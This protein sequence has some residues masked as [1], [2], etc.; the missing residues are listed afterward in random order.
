MA[1]MC[2]DSGN[3]MAIAQQ[4]IKQ[5]QQQEQLQQQ[6]Q[7]Q[8]QQQQQF[9]GVNPLCLSPWTSTTH[10]TLTNS[11][12][13]GYGLTG[14][15][16]A[17]PFQVAGGTDGGEPGFQFPNLEHHST[18]FRFADFGGGPGGEFDSDEWMESLIGGGDSTGSSNLQSG[19][20]A[21]QTSSEFTTLYGDPFSSCP[22]RLSIG[23]SPPPP[24]SS[25]L[26][27]VI[28]SET[29]KNLNSL[30]PQTSPWVAPSSSPPPIVQ[31]VCKESKVVSVDVLPC[32]SPESFSSKPLLKSLVECARLAE[33]EPENVVKSLIRL[34]ES[35]SQQGDPMERVGFYFL[36]ALYNGL[37]SCQAERTPSIF[38][39]TPEELTLSYKAFNDACPYSKF[40][41]LTANQAI[42]EATEKATRIHIVDF[43][44]VHG[45]QWAAFLQALATR[46][47][48]KPVSVRISGIPSVVLGNS[49]AA[50][51]LA[52]GNRLRD[53]AK[54]LDLNFE[55]EPILTPVQE[56]NGS[57]FRIDPDEILAVNFM[58]QLYN[59]LD[60][61]NVGV[62]TALSLAKSLNPSI[63]TLGEYEVN[64]NDVGFLQR[65]KNA[66]KYYS[67][68]F[69]SLD[70]SLTRDSPERV[71]VERLIL[72]RRIAGAVGLD[73]GGTRRECMEDKEHWRELMEGAGFKSVTLSHYA[74][75]Q[76]KILLWNYNY[77]SSFGLIDSAPGFLSL[78]WKDNPLLTVSSW[79]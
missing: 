7:Q 54:L 20:E 24:P 56:L 40:A 64:L 35:V 39:T 14:A 53:F 33:S 43:G 34:R 67:T 44:I 28:F 13:L 46:S 57:S 55:F 59:L 5:K 16:F 38:G 63:V 58:L 19:C 22:N 79:H 45:I 3:L 65:F 11:P 18:G 9:L 30:Q 68:V 69:E 73:D 42:L 78:A 48:G 8:Q 2:T 31:P 23:S 62:E 52:T 25:D 77:S 36:E 47:A 66:L 74:M 50:S 71:Q 4:V 27:G 51:L 61:T 37:S 10:Q 17:D 6:E 75:S 15:G 32:I 60:E 29:Q 26:N 41:H 70:P 49:P 76:A 21:W 12:T 72:G 1:Y